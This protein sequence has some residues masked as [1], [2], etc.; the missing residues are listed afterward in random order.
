MFISITTRK[1][2]KKK[3]FEFFIINVS[4]ERWRKTVIG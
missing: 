2:I 4:K 1:V 3:I